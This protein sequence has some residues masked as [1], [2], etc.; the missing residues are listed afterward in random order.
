MGFPK[1]I[2]IP[3]P[4]TLE[5][6]KRQYAAMRRAIFR[7]AAP[8]LVAKFTLCSDRERFLWNLWILTEFTWTSFFGLIVLCSDVVSS[9][10]FC[11]RQSLTLNK[12][13]ASKVWYAEGLGSKRI[14][15]WNWSGRALHVLGGES[16]QWQVCDCPLVTRYAEYTY[17]IWCQICPCYKL[18]WL[19]KH[20]TCTWGHDLSARENLRKGIW[21]E[22][23]RQRIDKRILCHNIS[24]KMF[25]L[26]SHAGHS[27]WAL[28]I[29]CTPPLPPLQGQAGVP[30]PQAWCLTIVKY[31]RPDWV[32]SSLW[33]V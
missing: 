1:Y 32:T 28:L 2:I 26:D 18:F 16:P 9:P 15:C 7:D 10:L 19:S 14:P 5:E 4:N 29:Y 20:L 11:H 17:G 13:H 27:W 22:G 31:T 33:C 25:F 6:R 8:E 23:V 30:H 3:H 21:S 12:H 24:S